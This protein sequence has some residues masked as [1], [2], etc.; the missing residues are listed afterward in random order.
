MC[1]DVSPYS[2][3]YVRPV[4]IDRNARLLPATIKVCAH[5]RPKNCGNEIACYGTRRQE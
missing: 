1:R 2:N 4:P 5:A 3:G